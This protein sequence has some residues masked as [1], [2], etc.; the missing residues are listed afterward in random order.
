M[1]EIIEVQNSDKKKS[2]NNFAKWYKLSI[3]NIDES[4]GKLGWEYKGTYKTLKDM[5]SV[6]NI[7]RDSI[8]AIFNG[9]K[10]YPLIRI[11]Q[12]FIE[13]PKK[14]KIKK[15]K[16]AKIIKRNKK[17]SN[18]VDKYKLMVCNVDESKGDITWECEANFKTLKNIASYLNV[19]ITTIHLIL[20]GKIKNKYPTYRIELINNE[21]KDETLKEV[22]KSNDT[23]EI[24]N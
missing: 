19:C 17:P 4:K 3:C 22:E 15:E 18:L 16:P 7:S 11:E 23:E 12:V 1:S 5:E 24:I 2:V 8:R 6:A 9:I 14:E 10:P 13:K 20:N 21:Q